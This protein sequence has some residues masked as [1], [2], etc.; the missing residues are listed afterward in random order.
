MSDGT[1]LTPTSGDS[2]LDLPAKRKT[3]ATTRKAPRKRARLQ[4]ARETSYSQSDSTQ[5]H[6][7]EQGSNPATP[8]LQPGKNPI[9]CSP[10]PSGVTFNFISNQFVQSK[11]RSWIPVLDPV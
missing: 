3:V 9:L 6:D 10:R 7:T 2:P 11:T 1:G 8:V 5:V 4:T